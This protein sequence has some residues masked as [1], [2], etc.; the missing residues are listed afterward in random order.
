LSAPVRYPGAATEHPAGA[1]SLRSRPVTRETSRG[2]C[3]RA[4]IDDFD[5]VREKAQD[6]GLGNVEFSSRAVR[7]PPAPQ[8]ATNVTDCQH[9]PHSSGALLTRSAHLA[10]ETS[11]FGSGHCIG[12]V[13]LGEID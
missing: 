3:V 13:L 9:G 2:P 10:D 8:A 12:A 11:P 1:Q 5:A 7:E 6:G 4:H